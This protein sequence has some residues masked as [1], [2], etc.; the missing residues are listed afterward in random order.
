[1]GTRFLAQRL[2][3]LPCLCLQ[4]R[5]ENGFVPSPNDLRLSKRLR[6][7]STCTNGV[8]GRV[9]SAMC[10]VVASLAYT[11]CIVEASTRGPGERRTLPDAR[12]LRPTS[13]LFV[14]GVRASQFITVLRGFH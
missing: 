11:R 12:G 10:V 1:M 5:S 4:T 7:R 2:D 6:H 13:G 3:C 9:R 8:F 14:R